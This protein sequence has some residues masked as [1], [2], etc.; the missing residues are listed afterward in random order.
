M[1]AYDYGTR[2]LALLTSTAMMVSFSSKENGNVSNPVVYNV[3][4]LFMNDTILLPII[5]TFIL[6]V[7]ASTIT[8]F[9]CHK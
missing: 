5:S 1:K 9:V 3:Y 8:V 2:M 4:G 6:C 7:Y